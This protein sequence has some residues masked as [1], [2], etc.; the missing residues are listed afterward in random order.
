MMESP[1]KRQKRPAEATNPFGCKLAALRAAMVDSV[2]E[3]DLRGIMAKLVEQAKAGDLN[4][5]REVLARVVG[6]PGDARDPDRISVESIAL[7]AD[8]FEAERLRRMRKPGFSD[9]LADMEFG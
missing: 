9:S 4:A 8:K 3:D 5:A 2:S 7:E 6:K 1:N